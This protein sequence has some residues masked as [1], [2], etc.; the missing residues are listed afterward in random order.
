VRTFLESNSS[1]LPADFS[2]SNG[3]KLLKD[4]SDATVAVHLHLTQDPQHDAQDQANHVD[5]D[6]SAGKKKNSN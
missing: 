5:C 3:V 4:C 2:E 6:D 1:L